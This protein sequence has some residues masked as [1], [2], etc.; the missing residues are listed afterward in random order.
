[1]DL[2]SF[3]PDASGL[4]YKSRWQVEQVFRTVKSAAMHTDGSQVTQARRFVKLAVVALIAAVRIMQIVIGRDGKT[5]QVLAD[6]MDPVHEPALTA[7][8]TKLEGR[9]EK[10]KNPN[11]T[12]DW[13]GSPGSWPGSAVGRD[14][15]LAGTS[16]PVQK[17]SLTASSASMASS[18]AGHFI[19]QMYDARSPP[20]RGHRTIRSMKSTQRGSVQQPGP[21]SLCC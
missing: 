5:G 11:H 6:A 16:R 9:T 7:L 20:G 19:P 18:K 17:P 2:F 10:L 8:N 12:A 21:G 13:P 15:P 1:L 14:I 4:L 3:S